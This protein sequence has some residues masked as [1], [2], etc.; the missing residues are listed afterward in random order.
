MRAS[1]THLLLLGGFLLVSAVVLWWAWLPPR[2][3]R[4][5][6]LVASGAGVVFLVLA[7]NTAGHREAETTGS[8][9]L[10]SAYVAGHAS[11]SASLPYY[12]ITTVCLLM[13]TAGLA[14]PDSAARRLAGHPLA[15]AVVVS[16]LA[17]VVRF[18]LEKAA[19][20]KGWTW[21]VGVTWLAPLVGAFLALRLRDQGRGVRT[22]APALLV[23]GLASRGWVA[24]T[25]AAAT[26]WKLGSHYD[27]SSAWVRLEDPLTGAARSFSPGSVTQMLYV[28]AVPQLLVWPLYTVLVGLAGASVVYLVAAAT[29]PRRED[30]AVDMEPAPQ[31]R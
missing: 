20:P 22:L 17:T 26:V 15:T 8:F 7:L 11:A 5:L 9:V 1:L 16:I 13:G 10:G 27:L 31:D 19:A 6:A 21:A 25:Y 4:G 2:L 28:V 12:V 29:R 18:A 3:R 23:Y 24:L 30:L 14:L